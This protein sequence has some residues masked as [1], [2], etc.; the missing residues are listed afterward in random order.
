MTPHISAESQYTCGHGLASNAPPQSDIPSVAPVHGKLVPKTCESLRTS[1]CADT[2]AQTPRDTYSPTSSEIG[3]D[4][5][6]TLLFSPTELAHPATVG[7]TL[8]P[9]RSKLFESHWSNQWLT[10][11]AQLEG[12]IFPSLAPERWVSS[13]CWFDFFI[14]V[15]NCEHLPEEWKVF[16]ELTL[17]CGWVFPFEGV[18]V[19]CDRPTKLT[20]DERFRLHADESSAIEFSD[21]FCAYARHGKLVIETRLVVK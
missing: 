12:Q 11:D 21:G 13:A 8:L 1:L 19:V 5:I 14:T 6:E 10:L 3:F 18:C 15:L 4:T 16:Q 9:Y 20:F 2:S 17:E 7:V